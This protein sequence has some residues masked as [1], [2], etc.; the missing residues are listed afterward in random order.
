MPKSYGR[1]PSSPSLDWEQIITT[2]DKSK[3]Y[4]SLYVS[5]I[6]LLWFDSVSTGDKA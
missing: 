6:S 1:L 4:L 2:K 5:V 3:A